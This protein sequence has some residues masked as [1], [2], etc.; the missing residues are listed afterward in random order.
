MREAALEIILDEHAAL[1]AML[2]SLRMM[3]ERNVPCLAPEDF[4]V[5]RAM[6]FYT[7]EFP[8]RL[9]HPKESQFLFPLLAERAPSVRQ[10]L[11]RLNLEHMRL[12]LWTLE[13]QQELLSWELMG[14]ARREAVVTGVKSYVSFYLDHMR[15]EE[16]EILPLAVQLLDEADWTTL[17]DAFAENRDPLTGRFSS[18]PQ[19]AHLFQLILNNAPEP[20]GL[21][22]P[23]K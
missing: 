13:L 15:L 19:Y 14:D 23:V 8:E 6:L 5:L 17:H 16:T 9:H 7:S 4:S 10:T 2:K 1:A 21:R 11:A 20:I 3:V 18:P 22:R 12:E